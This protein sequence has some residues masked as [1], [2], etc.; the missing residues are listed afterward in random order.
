MKK[1]YV[2][3]FYFCVYGVISDLEFFDE[4]K[5]YGYEL[6]NDEVDKNCLGNEIL[7][8]FWWEVMDIVLCGVVRVVG[9]LNYNVKKFRFN[10]EKY[11]FYF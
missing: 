4:D 8:R 9:K 7:K 2:G 5:Y 11:I 6:E 10:F 3:E 1:R